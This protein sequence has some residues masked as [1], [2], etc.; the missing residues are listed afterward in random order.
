MDRLTGAVE[1]VYC[2]VDEGMDRYV[3]STGLACPEGCG[4]CCYSPNVKATVLECVPL[5]SAVHRAGRAE[6]IL[7][8]IESTED[9]TCVAFLPDPDD[10]KKGRCAFYRA[11]PLVCRLFGFAARRNKDGKDQ[12]VICP[13][14]REAIPETCERAERAVGEGLGTPVYQDCSMK[15]AG[16]DFSLSGRRNPIN[17][18][19][20]KALDRVGLRAKMQLTDPVE[21]S[22]GLESSVSPGRSHRAR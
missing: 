13:V 20:R 10:R 2:E 16:L 6:E 18:A 14:M 5:A 17:E 1:Q 11:R 12:A 3:R 9:H 7:R 19:I 8:R 15:V 21:N 4:A 22:S